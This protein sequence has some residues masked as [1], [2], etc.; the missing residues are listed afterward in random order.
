MSER[1]NLAKTKGCDG[2][3]PDNVNAYENDSGFK[4]NA[5]DQITYNIWLAQQVH[6]RDLSIGLKNDIDQVKVLVDHFDW[7]LNEQCWEYDECN[8]L[9][10]FIKGTIVLEYVKLF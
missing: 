9:E 3:D 7:M 5:T 6:A 8:T 1:M 2:V 4:L 10:P